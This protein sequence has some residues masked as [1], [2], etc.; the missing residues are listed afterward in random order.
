MLETAQ[1]ENQQ[2]YI[3]VR[4]GAGRVFV[5][6]APVELAESPHAAAGVYRYVLSR[7]GIE[8]PFDASGLSPSVLVRRRVFKDSVLYLF[9]SESPENQKMD[10]RDK[11]TG[12]RIQLSVPALRTE[13]LLIDRATGKIILTYLRPE[14]SKATP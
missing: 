6:N 9:A 2:S 5:V 12:A 3:E 8:P 1:L 13:M 11:L 10:I 14:W 7:V 4:Y